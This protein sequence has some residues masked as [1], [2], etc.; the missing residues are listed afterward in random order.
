MRCLLTEQAEADLEA[1]G[2]YIAQDNPARAVTFVQEVRERCDTIAATPEA[3]PVAF[4]IDGIAVRRI[5]FGRYLIFYS[6]TVDS[7]V[8]LRVLHGARDFGRAW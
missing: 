3:A 4:R 7:T 8:V 6:V 5:V 2:D 1:L